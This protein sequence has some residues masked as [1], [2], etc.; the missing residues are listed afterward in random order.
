MHTRTRTGA[1]AVLHNSS[2]HRVHERDYD[3]R[4]ILQ[5]AGEACAAL[6]SPVLVQMRPGLSGGLGGEGGDEDRGGN[7][8][9][10]GREGE[11]GGGYGEGGGGNGG[12]G[13][14]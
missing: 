13:G 10:G 9:G 7:G 6:M 2:G 3:R 1:R 14:R 11:G 4:S 8:E 5:P 12:G